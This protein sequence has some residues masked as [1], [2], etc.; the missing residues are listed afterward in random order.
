M[1]IEHC[2]VS[3][4]QRRPLISSD[5]GTWPLAGMPSVMKCYQDYLDQLHMSILGY[6]TTDLVII[7]VLQWMNLHPRTS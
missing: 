3:A 4:S 6:A 2:P 5:K 7:L 1:R